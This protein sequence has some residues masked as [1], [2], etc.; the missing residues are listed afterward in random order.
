MSWV[1]LGLR[2][3]IGVDMLRGSSRNLVVYASHIMRGA[4]HVVTYDDL[5]AT[6][7]QGE[8]AACA[9]D[10]DGQCCDINGKEHP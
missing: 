10:Q 5:I 3:V 7:A 1:T 2:V 9:G 8:P 6:R 4:P